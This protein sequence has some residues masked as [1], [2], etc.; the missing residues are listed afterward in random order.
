VVG[1]QLVPVELIVT[2]VQGVVGAVR[3][4]IKVVPPPGNEIEEATPVPQSKKEIKQDPERF[5]L[6]ILQH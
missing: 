5:L 4:Q 2:P 1:E 6:E 3:E